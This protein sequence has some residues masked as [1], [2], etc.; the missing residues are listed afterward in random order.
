MTKKK[1]IPTEITKDEMEDALKRSGYL[2]EQRT[3]SVFERLNYYLE[4]NPIYED[5]EQHISR[6]FDFKATKTI[7]NQETETEIQYL[8]FGECKNNPF[9]IVFFSSEVKADL[10]YREFTLNFTGLPSA[11]P[12]EKNEKGLFLLKDNRIALPRLLKLHLFHHYFKENPF[13]QYCTFQLKKNIEKNEWMATHDKNDNE[14]FKKL[15]DALHFEVNRNIFLSSY[16]T[17]NNVDT[18]PFKNIIFYYPIMVFAGE[19]FEYNQQS[20]NTF[21]L[22]KT[23]HIKYKKSCIIGK[24]V[25][26][27]F[28]DVIKESYLESYLKMIYEEHSNILNEIIKNIDVIKKTIDSEKPK[29]NVFPSEMGKALD[30]F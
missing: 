30:K 6:E 11:Y 13:T 14:D 4:T 18:I 28:I 9:P 12:N 26:N 19:M 22:K 1:V 20:N 25:K 27:Y 10:V 21:L 15:I 16:D 23:N 8:L 2:I 7:K 29:V 24:G 3:F 5:P 17:A